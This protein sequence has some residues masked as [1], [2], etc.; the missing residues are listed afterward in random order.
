MNDSKTFEL[1]KL[2]NDQLDQTL[3]NA[4][5]KEREILTVILKNIIE[6]DRRKL[7]LTFAY[8]SLFEYL[9][10]HIGYS[11]GSAQRRI[12]AARLSKE[13]PEVISKLEVGSL[14]LAQIG[15]LQ[16]SMRQYLAE[17][18][19]NDAN[20]NKQ[21]DKNTIT[22]QTKKQIVDSL[23]GKSFAESQVLVSQVLNI[24]IKEQ[25]KV[26]HQKDESVRL[27]LTLTKAQWGKLTRVRE[28]LSNLMPNGSM[29]QA[30]EYALDEVIAQKL[31]KVKKPKVV[32]ANLKVSTAVTTITPLV[33][34]ET[35]STMSIRELPED[36]QEKDS[37]I[38]TTHKTR[39]PLSKK[40]RDQISKRDLCCQFTDKQSGRICGSKWRLH[41]DHI[42][43]VWAGG[44]NAIHNLRILCAN[45]NLE[46]YRS[47]TG[48]SRKF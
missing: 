28:L 9:T 48:L 24:S 10:K 39:M 44:E 1:K 6:V 16:K 37:R 18:K 26:M 41:V 30:L 35:E 45:H 4:V 2:T 40:I 29:D 19:N 38:E 23:S 32:K 27:E 11:A 5:T 15:L 8:P 3:K 36:N 7:Y 47:Q 46:L 12:D 42:Q 31:P 14:N 20:N 21:N 25:P 33:S 43:P 13:I 17:N 34:T 22:T